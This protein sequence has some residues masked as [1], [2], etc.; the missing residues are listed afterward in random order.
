MTLPVKDNFLSVQFGAPAI[1]YHVGLLQRQENLLFFFSFH[2]FYL[3]KKKKVL[4][5]RE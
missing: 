4:I 1:H 2:N 3:Q 5:N